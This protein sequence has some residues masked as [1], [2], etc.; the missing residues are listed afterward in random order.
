MFVKCI[1]GISSLFDVVV[2]H[3]HLIIYIA[4][5]IEPTRSSVSFS[6]ALE[7]RDPRTIKRGSVGVCLRF[8]QTNI[9]ATKLKIIKIYTSSIASAFGRPTY[10]GRPTSGSFGRPLAS[11]RST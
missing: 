7:Y 10:I 4:Q 3:D 11:G 8:P 6:V 9:N 1:S 2:D 5:D